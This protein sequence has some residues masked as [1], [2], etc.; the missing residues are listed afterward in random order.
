MDQRTPSGPEG[1]S[2]SWIHVCRRVPGHFCVPIMPRNWNS[3]YENDDTPWD[4]GYAAPP[5]VE[6]LERHRVDGRTLV[7]GCGLGHD[8]RLLA[9]QGAEVLGLDIAPA[10]IE[11]A[12]S[13]DPVGSESYVLGNF[14]E[15]EKQ[16]QGQFDFV[17]EHTCLCAIEPS[18]RRVYAESIAAALKPG[19]HYLAVFFRDVPEYEGD[20]PPHPISE[21]EILELFGACFERIESFVP[22]QTYPSRPVGCEEVRLMRLRLQSDE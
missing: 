18:E 13:I 15:L 12:R 3:A 5:L 7:P 16:Y 4:K 21:D 17:F 22:R 6:F 10:A 19:G 9:E 8:V 14:L 1:S 11:K 2:G 20:G